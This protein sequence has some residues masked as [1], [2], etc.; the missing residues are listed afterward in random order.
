MRT[1][2]FKRGL[3]SILL[4]SVI[5]LS[6]TLIQTSHVH[7]MGYTTHQFITSKA[8]EVFS[9]N[10][11]FSVHYSTINDYCTKPDGWK[12]IDNYERF[13]HWYH[14][15]DSMGE[16]EYYR[17]GLPD[18]W[19]ILA[20]GVLPWAVEDNFNK[21]VQLLT[22]ENWEGAAQLAGVISHYVEDA[23]NP[24]HATSDYNP[25]GN[26]GPYEV[27]VN[28]QVS[29]DNVTIPE[30][31]PHEVDNVFDLM[32]QFLAEGY[33][34]TGY[35]EN[36]LNY[37]LYENVLWNDTIKD[38]TESRLREDVSIL[39][40]LWYTG[41][42]RA[43]L[44]IAAPTLTLPGNGAIISD[45]TPTFEWSST[46][47]GYQFEYA[48]DNAFTTNVTIVK[49]FTTTSYTPTTPLADGTWYWRVRSGDNTTSVGL[50][51][52]TWQFTVETWAGTAVFSLVDLYTVNVEENLDL[53]RGPKLVVKF[54]D[55]S[56]AYENEN[57]IENFSPPWHVE[58]NESA[59][60]PEGTSVEKAK[61]V[62]TEDNTENVISTIA[63]YTVRKVDLEVRF[64]GIP[65]L[66]ALASP[67]G[68]VALEIEF[69]DIPLYWALAPS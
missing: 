50:W 36:D 60:H 35:T 20:K 62:L 68:K 4:V 58:E 10:S 28:Y 31:V 45:K 57:V 43:N 55:Y 7:A 15:D 52:E 56:D 47:A 39:A 41:M 46:V 12:S 8:V 2:G 38:I 48:T 16:N 69:S 5:V 22:E 65:L 40:N 37:W 25:S 13:R 18:N 61:L 33:E 32:K 53:Y 3:G 51:S 49:D 23:P 11:F 67:A 9:D 6:M 26:H 34:F 1:E 54:Y 21:F 42:I 29:V 44:V 19:F 27:E 64:T 59:R 24:L 30:Y 66:W 63:S 14:M 17:G